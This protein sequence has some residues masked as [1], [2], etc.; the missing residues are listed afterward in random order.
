MKA[1]IRIDRENEQI[2]INSGFAKNADK[3]NSMEY[4]T[5]Q[6]CRKDYPNYQVITRTIKKNP[7]K[8]CY[9]D[10]TYDYMR[11]YIASHDSELASA[12]F[13]ELILRTRCHST[14]YRYPTVKKW[15]LETY[16]E[17]KNILG[18]AVGSLQ[19]TLP[20]GTTLALPEANA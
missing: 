12:Y 20:Q 8:E 2:I 3:F 16:P 9:K 6:E 15:F 5:L 19:A 4:R 14:G 7:K 18:L 11:N 1:Q 10:L 17:V 13:E